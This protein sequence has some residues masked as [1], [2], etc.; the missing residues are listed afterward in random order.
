MILIF[1]KINNTLKTMINY[2][3]NNVKDEQVL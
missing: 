2:E 1:R 3:T